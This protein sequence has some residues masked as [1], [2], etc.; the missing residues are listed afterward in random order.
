M[1]DEF[2]AH[3]RKHL[4]ITI[5]RLMLPA[6]GYRLNESLLHGQL[7]S[8]GFSIARDQVR[9]EMAWLAQQGLV[10]VDD[11]DGLLVAELSLQGV[12]VANGHATHPD[13]QRPSPKRR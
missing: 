8:R 4:R 12:D 5:L 6:P 9:T 13:V 3:W 10:H 1:S 11:L 2:T 7:P